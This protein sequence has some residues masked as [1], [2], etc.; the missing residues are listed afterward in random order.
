MEKVSI[1]IAYSH[2]D[3]D[4]LEELKIQLKVFERNNE[5]EIWYDGN[6]QPGQY[7]DRE[8]KQK[9]YKADLVLPLISAYFIGSDYAYEQELQKALSRHRIGAT[10]VA[11]IIIRDTYWEKTPLKEIQVLPRGAKA[12]EL[13]ENQ[14]TAFKSIVKEIDNLI[15]KIRLNK[16]GLRLF[17]EKDFEGAIKEYEKAIK[18]DDTCARAFINKS[19]AYFELGL[20]EL[21]LEAQ[22]QAVKYNQELL[23]QNVLRN[24]VFDAK[25]IINDQQYRRTGFII[26]VDGQAIISLHQIPLSSSEQNTLRMVWWNGNEYK[27][28]EIN[29]IDYQNRFAF[30]TL[31]FP[32]DLTFKISLLSLKYVPNEV[33][34]A[35]GA[36]NGRHVYMRGFSKNQNRTNSLNLEGRI[37]S[38]KGVSLG[39]NDSVSILTEKVE[40]LVGAPV[41][42]LISRAI[43]GVQTQV[44]ITEREAEVKLFSEEILEYTTQNLRIHFNPIIVE[45]LQPTIIDTIKTE[46]SSQSKQTESSAFEKKQIT[47]DP[48]SYNPLFPINNKLNWALSSPIVKVWIDK[49]Q[50]SILIIG[51]GLKDVYSIIMREVI[52]LLIST[53][54]SPECIIAN[55]CIYL[56]LAQGNEDIISEEDNSRSSE[57]KPD[58]NEKDEQ[59]QLGKDLIYRFTQNSMGGGRQNP[60]PGA[61]NPKI[62]F[63]R[64]IG[65][66]SKIES[67]TGLIEIYDQDSGTIQ[68]FNLF[69]SRQIRNVIRRNNKIIIEPCLE[70]QHSFVQIQPNILFQKRPKNVSISIP[71]DLLATEEFVALINAYYQLAASDLYTD[72]KRRLSFWKDRLERDT[73]AHQYYINLSETEKLNLEPVVITRGFNPVLA[74]DYPIHP[75][76]KPASEFYLALPKRKE[77]S[78]KYIKELSSLEKEINR[79]MRAPDSGI[80]KVFE[81][82]M[83]DC[84]LRNVPPSSDEKV[85]TLFEDWRNLVYPGLF[86]AWS[87]YLRQNNIA[88]EHLFGFN[89]FFSINYG[90]FDEEVNLSVFGIYDSNYSTIELNRVNGIARIFD[91]TYFAKTEPS[92]FQDHELYK[93]LSKLVSSLD[94]KSYKQNYERSRDNLERKVMMNLAFERVYRC[95][96][97]GAFHTMRTIVAPFDQMEQ[98]HEIGSLY[99]AQGFVKYFDDPT[100]YDQSFD[101]LVKDILEDEVQ[102]RGVTGVRRFIQMAVRFDRPFVDKYDKGELL[103]WN[104]NKLEYPEKNI[105]A[106]LQ[107]L[108]GI[109]LMV[110]FTKANSNIQF[111]DET[112]NTLFLKL[113]YSFE[114]AFLSIYNDFPI[115]PLFNDI[116][117]TVSKAPTNH[118][119]FGKIKKR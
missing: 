109:Q 113:A 58:E 19:N 32:E 80:Q 79:K 12:I 6:I 70:N 85:V 50:E 107:L 27:K 37:K 16:N 4:F 11:P 114:K 56:A 53:D 67:E 82:F 26:S 118:D 18:I 55:G 81:S 99:L 49:N 30:V 100:K 106:L 33:N 108:E 116:W 2:R 44:N 77:T 101:D 60:Q 10:I 63:Q 117:R 78:K 3:S 86:E 72:V 15:N 71:K 41:V 88:T 38:S 96:K 59:S 93:S 92:N 111:K 40:D 35:N 25:I 91:P 1:F 17:A 62:A 90:E 13:W 34:L 51:Q 95:Y 46:F 36:L 64:L 103:S 104:P 48:I 94:V 89:T 23:L 5:I 65:Q 20:Y 83:F 21:A 22:V 52:S 66:L 105:Y 115:T 74:I 9:L 31:D 75:E 42:D 43:I 45:E 68:D 7:W 73:R 84:A 69:L 110:E 39:N 76:T 61:L 102:E 87:D 112:Q 97:M 24:L 47:P 8:I 29:R 14:S 54:L 98:N 119:Y 57:E 28:I